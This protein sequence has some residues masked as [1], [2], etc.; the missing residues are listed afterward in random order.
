MALPIQSR[1]SSRRAYAWLILGSV[2]VGVGLLL[3]ICAQQA[4]GASPT[5]DSG[6]S[7]G[8]RWERMSGVGCVQISLPAHGQYSYT[9]AAICSE[10][11]IAVH[12]PG[13]NAY[14]SDPNVNYL[15]ECI[16]AEEAA[17]RALASASSQ[18][19][20]AAADGRDGTLSDD[21]VCHYDA[22]H[23]VKCSGPLG[24]VADMLAADGTTAPDPKDADL[25][26]VAATGILLL[27]VG[28]AVVA[29]S[30]GGLGGL[31][32]GAAGG[33]AG[34]SGGAP[35]SSSGGATG[36]GASGAASS[37]HAATGGHSLMTPFDA[38]AAN[39]SA[40]GVVPAV[41]GIN[42]AVPRVELIQGGLSIFRSMKRVTDQADPTGYSPGD[43][44]QL[45]GDAAGIAALASVLA[46]GIGLISLAAG[47]AAAVMDVK[48][49]QEI[50]GQMRSNF[51]RLGYMQGVLDE[52][53]SHADHELGDLDPAE[54]D[55]AAAAPP[56]RNPT[57]LS[58]KD[59]RTARTLW[60]AKADAAFDALARAR[61]ERDDLDDR[62]SDLAYQIDAVGDLLGRVDTSGSV[63]LP[64]YLVGTITYGRGWY[65]AGDSS[66]MAAALRQ[67]F[68]KVRS[69]GVE[70]PRR[71]ADKSSTVSRPDETAGP[72]AMTLAEWAASQKVADGRMAVLQALAGLERW[73]GFYDALASSVQVRINTLRVQADVAVAARRDL[74]AEVQRRAL[75]RAQ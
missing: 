53:V 35:G 22:G 16:T 17:A 5:P 11:Y 31:A 73:R 18:P 56:P 7:D 30:S 48:S 40:L 8:F 51:G 61:Q 58:A 64:Q 15:V 57:V 41:S 62:R 68:E 45:L 71:G 23:S 44:A 20:Q 54:M 27:S 69:A 59:L 26:G 52:N 60:A 25:G 65:F 74:A 1:A 50:V 28:G 4:R 63:G 9:S 72:K 75:E 10:P 3:V 67:S 14:G 70:R 2:L 19:T 33:A 49:P 29:S 42:L 24:E 46:P 66:K 37:G 38:A 32:G 39:T 55:P 47:G 6:C 12:A 36:G 13:P 43:V 21:D 34:G